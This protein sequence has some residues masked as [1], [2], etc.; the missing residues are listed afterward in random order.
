MNSS[1]HSACSSITFIGSG[2]M[3]SSI[4][5]GLI[6]QG[7][8]ANAITA[9][10]PNPESLSSLATRFGINTST[11]NDNASRYC[12]VIVLAVKP[13]IL[14]LVCKAMKTTLANRT[15]QPLIISVAAGIGST[16]IQ[17]WLDQ[18]IAIVRCMPN[19]PALV[20]QGASGLFANSHTS[21]QQQQ[22]AETLL[23]AVGYTT[24]VTNEEL[25]DAVTAVSGSGP[26]Y[27]FLLME[28]MINAGVK[29]GLSKQSATELTLQTA[30][31]A[32]TL[33]KSS[34]VSVD[35][36]RRQVTSPAG[37]T[38]QAIQHFEN[39]GL[40]AIVEEA[41]QAC[42]ERSRAMAKEFS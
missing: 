38:E 10:D 7:Y 3:A 36:L 1:T 5:G 15:E 29:Q 26:A 11:D 12:D 35:E 4:I 28:A 23:N 13:Q 20:Q 27:F 34:H 32:A 18:E 25:I 21:A 22:I 37:T 2:N 17:K 9:C 33:A 41:M 42:A 19:T 30:L 16:Q 31:G 6:E 39:A 24:W 40:H 14:S 8:P